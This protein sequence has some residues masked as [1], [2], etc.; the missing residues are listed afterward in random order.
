MVAQPAQAQIR[1]RPKFGIGEVAN[2]VR[3]S[4]DGVIRPAQFGGQLPHGQPC[5]IAQRAVGKLLN[6]VGERLQRFVVTLVPAQN[7]GAFEHLI[8]ARFEDGMRRL[9]R[10][11]QDCT[12]GEEQQRQQQ[13]DG[14]HPWRVADGTRGFH[15]E[16]RG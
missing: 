12:P 1:L 11:R 13:A 5:V 4:R 6:E 14:T 3:V 16:L 9:G 10:R 8:S 15:C 7:L 2:Q